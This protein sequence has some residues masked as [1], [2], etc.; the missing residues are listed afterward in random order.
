[1]MKPWM[2][3]L[4]GGVLAL[5]GAG[6]RA[7][8]P[9]LGADA[10]P[11]QGAAMPLPK[12]TADSAMGNTINGQELT[13]KV[14]RASN[15]M[16]LVDHEGIV[17]PL[18]INAKTEFGDPSIKRGKDLKEGQEIRA[19]FTVKSTAN[20][21]TRIS[22]ETATGGSGLIQDNGM[23]K[24]DPALN[25]VPK[26]RPFGDKGQGGSGDVGTGNI[27]TGDVNGNIHDSTMPENRDVPAHLNP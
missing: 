1:M 26:S 2:T 14:V 8:S 21:A 15:K 12:Q 3:M 27:G 13:G 17:V 23:L 10:A 9:D 22:L 5:S 4:A 18:K 19:A 16:I 24:G 20:W 6:V 25:S 11:P 7:A